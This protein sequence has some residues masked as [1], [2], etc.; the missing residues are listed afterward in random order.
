[1]GEHQSLYVNCA[2]C[3]SVVRRVFVNAAGLCDACRVSN[4]K[5]A[6]AH[7]RGIAEGIERA[8]NRLTNE[9]LAPEFACVEARALDDL[10]LR[11]RAL[12]AK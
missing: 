6:A 4:D 3:E 10:V 11:I 9:L 5:E 1:V 2:R 12:G 7:D 8:A